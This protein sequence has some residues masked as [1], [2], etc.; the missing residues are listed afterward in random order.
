MPAKIDSPT[1]WVG[2]FFFEIDK[3]ECEAYISCKL[4]KRSEIIYSNKNQYITW[5]NSI[6]KLV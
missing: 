5:V 3:T 1:K 2:R 6:G 4:K